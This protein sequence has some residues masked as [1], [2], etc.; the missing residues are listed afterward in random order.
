MGKKLSIL[1][2]QNKVN[3]IFNDIVIIKRLGGE[4]VLIEHEGIK[5]SSRITN[6]FHGKMPSIKSAV[7][8]NVTFKHKS[9]KVHGNKYDYSKS[10]YI[11]A[12][13]P[14]EIIC[15]IH[16]SF[17]S[18]P[19]NHLKGCGCND[20]GNDNQG[21]GWSYTDWEKAGNNSNYFDSFKLYVIECWND[22]EHFYK[23][24]KT[25]RSIDDRFKS[26]I[27]YKWNI[28]NVINGD[29]K[30]ISDLE[31]KLNKLHKG[32][33]YKPLIWFIGHTE[34]FSELKGGL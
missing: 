27:P 17:F 4:Y 10:I 9:E 33:K 3:I 7:D 30:Y 13:T 34:C 8:K 23:I 11:N 29:A 25:F 28:I 5:Y 12:K 20:C 15:P 16:G 1:E 32:V 2:I 22:D 21:G 18:L 14:I 6:L 19:T 26:I 24:G 31:T